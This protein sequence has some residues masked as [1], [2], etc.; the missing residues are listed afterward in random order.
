MRLTLRTLLA[1]LDDILEP[2]HAHEIGEKINESGFAASLVS[3][4]RDVMRRRRLT[5]PALSG[6]G[7]GIDPNTMAEY[8]DN[9][10]SPEKIADVEKIC[11]E[12]DV[13][14]AEAA[15]CHQILTLVLGD[16]V[17]IPAE[18]RERMY[19]LGP[20]AQKASVAAARELVEAPAVATPALAHVAPTAAAGTFSAVVGQGAGGDSWETQT[21]NGQR[22]GSS[23]PV[24]AASNSAVPDYLRSGSSWKTIL[25]WAVVAA[26]AI[27][28]GSL[29][30]LDSPFTA[31]S[32]NSGNSGNNKEPQV[33][34][35]DQGAEK[36]VG[37]SNLP[38]AE[39]SGD[40]L[41]SPETDVLIANN[42][43]KKV[44]EEGID[45]PAPDEDPELALPSKGDDAEKVAATSV[46]KKKPE[47]MPDEGA[48]DE[49]PEVTKKPREVAAVVPP[50]P[51]DGG[52]PSPPSPPA[53]YTSADGVMLHFPTREQKWLVMPRRAFVHTSD[54]LAVPQP[55]DGVVQF[56]DGRGT[57]TIKG[58]TS[59]RV[60][61]ARDGAKFGFELERGRVVLRPGK[62]ADEAAEKEGQKALISVG[63]SVRGES[64]RI[65]LLTP[66]TVC[67]VEVAPKEPNQF[68][69]DLG[70]NSYTGGVFVSTGGARLID[71]KGH[72]EV[73]SGPG[74]YEL[75]PDVRMGSKEGDQAP[76]PP[77]LTVP[78][79]MTPQPPSLL[80][81]QYS[82][83]FE[84]L[85]EIGQPAE[86]SIASVVRDR[87][88]KLSQLAVECLGLI[89]AHE[90]LVNS[91]ARNDHEESR[92]AA[93]Y[94]LRIW[95]PLAHENRDMLKADLAKRFPPAEADAV[96]HLLWGYNE[97]DARN[98]VT[99]Q[100]LVRWLGS[101]EIA[102]REL[103]FYQVYRLTDKKYDYRTSASPSQLQT[104]VNRWQQHIN[105]EGAL[106][107]KK[108]AP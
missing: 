73:I 48:D 70:P 81:K 97:E 84:K 67:G 50:T 75:T 14:L 7:S 28:W 60:T 23:M 19:G 39:R 4:I 92:V 9:T 53:I 2:A 96:Y 65:E 101:D 64:W 76:P 15:A 87:R 46:R 32:S 100:R 71:A 44:H 37:H 17:E 83:P 31:F 13:H 40:D 99:S 27:F 24:G 85:F 95:L 72:E 108:S 69:Q 29:L 8:L 35:H 54:R 104:S 63:L 107:P 78:Q 6:P 88:P 91:L 57:L 62:L 26:I 42:K 66:D 79:W 30:F 5:A 1:Y 20:L 77:L 55:F 10:L 82:K 68:E 45:V 12:S 22:L 43:Q 86:S 21:R 105:K 11:L 18:T 74:W 33:A 58:G 89:E 93:I 61:A 41:L 90:D 16:P 3:R 25:P 103:A 34:L 36:D 52:L 102:I 94:A 49:K 98:K 51:D 59:L 47:P 106:S 80:V 38:P 56:D